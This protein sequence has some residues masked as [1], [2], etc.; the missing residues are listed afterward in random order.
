MRKIEE[1]AA[2]IVESNIY[3]TI[4]TADQDGKPWASPV[5][6]AYDEEYNLYWVSYKDSTH[7]KNI[8]SRKEVGIVIF[9]STLPEG[10]GEGVYFDA[11]AEA[12]QSTAD[13]SNAME[14]LSKRVK[15]DEFKVKSI[16]Q[17]SGKSVWR[18]YKAMPLEIT[19][20]A[21]SSVNGQHVDK[22]I[23]VRIEV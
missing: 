21:G 2:K 4:A 3:M 13:I 18:I 6:F 12:L 14:I 15:I 1:H 16:E 9:N 22:R 20:L 5:F 10:E 17:V 19:Q 8:H 23:N 11:T 7:S